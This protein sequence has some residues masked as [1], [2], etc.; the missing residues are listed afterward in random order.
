VRV[1][2]R[3]VRIRRADLDQFLESASTE[4]LANATLSLDG[5]DEQLS[6]S[7]EKVRNA[8]DRGNTSEVADSLAALGDMALSLAATLRN[9][10][11]SSETDDFRR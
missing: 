3:R 1:G 5:V 6:K 8:I 9:G 4:P 10:S 7:F 2:Q 11:E